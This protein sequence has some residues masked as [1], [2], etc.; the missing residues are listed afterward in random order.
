MMKLRCIATPTWTPRCPHAATKS[1]G[2]YTCAD[3]RLLRGVLDV[4]NTSSTRQ[5]LAFSEWETVAEGQA[6][7]DR[8]VNWRVA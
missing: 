8:F 7:I 2:T 5:M 3:H 6:L 4:W 1:D